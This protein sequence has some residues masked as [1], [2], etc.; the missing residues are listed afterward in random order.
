MLCPAE[1][2][3]SLP[4]D[5]SELEG[6]TRSVLSATS[7]ASHLLPP[8]EWLRE[9][10]FE[11]CQRL[12]EQSNRRESRGHPAPPRPTALR[13]HLASALG[14]LPALGSPA[15]PQASRTQGTFL[16]GCSDG[17]AETRWLSSLPQEP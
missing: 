16:F 14:S 4:D 3:F 17:D 11:Y 2:S 7:T 5:K 8:Q 13:P 10:A 15:S 1:P 12:L 6:S 9:K